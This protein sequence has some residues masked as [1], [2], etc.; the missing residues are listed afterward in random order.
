M[1]RHAKGEFYMRFL[2]IVFTSLLLAGCTSEEDPSTRIESLSGVES[3]AD[4]KLGSETQQLNAWLDK[5]F[6]D[7]LD[8]SPM[9]KTRQGSK[10]DYSMLDDVSDA[11]RE[12]VLS[13][14]R[15]SVD[16]MRATFNRDQ[17]DDQGKLSW[18]LWAFLLTRAEAS[19]PYQRHRY[20]FGRRGP[21]TSLPNSLINYHKVDSPEDMLAYIARINDSYR[22]LSQYL[23]QAKKSA[24]AGIRA[25]Y[26]DYEISMSQS[27][28]V[29]TGEP[30]TS[31]EGDSAIWADITAKIATLEKGGKINAQESQ[32]LYDAAQRAL[33]EAFKPAYNA[34]LSWQASDIDNVSSKAKGVWALPNGELFYDYRLTQ[35]TTLPLSAKDIHE[36]GLAEVARIQ[37]EMETIKKNVGFDG[38]LYE[39]FTFMRE[40]DQFYFQNND[41]GRQ[42]YLSMAEGFLEDV[43]QKLPEYFGL[44]PKGKLEVRRVEPFREQPGAA[45]HYMRGTLDGKRPGVFYI[46]LSDMRA[47]AKYR[48]ENLAYHEGLPGHHMQIAIQ[49]E[50]E[51]IPHFRRYHGYTAYSE[52]WGLY[53]EY[54]GKDMGF[55]KDDYS[56]FGRLS[57]EIW[58][59]IRLVVDTGIHAKQWT[60]AQAIDYAL[61]NSP[62][63][64]ASVKS[65]VRRYF[66]AP[67]QATAYKI[68]MLKILELR[69]RAMT[70]LG[71][72]FD[73]RD[74]HDVILG[75]GPLPLPLLE[76]QVDTWI[77]KQ[78]G[79]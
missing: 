27:Q 50:L 13:W 8:F 9:A 26:F 12:K 77:A 16:H 21:H 71:D 6:D 30:F 33:L 55:Y 73:Y 15:R 59:A 38:S 58:R 22:Y 18:D 78:K 29:I 70:A 4:V 45:A 48:L 10:S 47:T 51:N 23:D 11:Q 63:P 1:M 35:M 62:R 74:F 56:D 60:E 54:L 25:P 79:L 39:F 69:S 28:R 65:E 5:E 32:V 43:E 37:S 20:V 41:E 14:R 36:T 34:I 61:R 57:G 49:Q 76:S 31:E 67:G 64:I 24:A 7:Y 17:L 3:A 2:I 46:H 66:N 52:G 44:L 19:L 53:A 75:N 68:G 40:D 42:K 72:K